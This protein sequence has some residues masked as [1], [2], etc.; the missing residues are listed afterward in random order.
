LTLKEKLRELD[1]VQPKITAMQPA[2][3]QASTLD[4]LLGGAEQDG[5]FWWSGVLPSARCMAPPVWAAYT[6]S[7]P[8]RWR[9]PDKM[10]AWPSSIW[11]GLCFG[12]RNDRTRWRNG[13][14]C[15]SCWGWPLRGEEFVVRQYFLRQP[16]EEA[17][18]LQ[19]LQALLEECMGLVTFNGKSFDIPLLRTRAV[20]HRLSVDFE[21]LHHFDV[22]H[23]ARRLWKDQV[24][25]CSLGGLESSILR[26]H[27]QQD[28]PG[29]LIPQIYF[30]FC[31]M[32]KLHAAGCSAHNRQ[33]I[34]STAALLVR[35]AQLVQNPLQDKRGAPISP[36]ELRRVAMLYRQLGDFDASARLF[37][38]LL[39]Q[40]RSAPRLEDHLVLG[41][42]YKSQRRHEEAKR[43]WHETV[44]RLPFHPLPYIEL[45][46]HFEHR[47][48]AIAQA[49]EWVERAMRNLLLSE[50]LGRSNGW[51]LYKN[52][53]LH[54]QARLQ[55][56]LQK[57]PMA[58]PAA[59]T[60]R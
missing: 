15:F 49:L 2:T 19:Q 56:K 33:D 23:A 59:W 25:S 11:P 34:V 17:A 26:Q 52:D 37:E 60:D 57:L 1:R 46:K 22:L 53:L 39:Q 12:Y 18:M 47:E 30:D 13:N 28:I 58:T 36:S 45:A 4:D 55:R 43:L 16:Y 54:R 42:C 51:L 10:N 40:P 27:R 32:A 14:P 35:I 29:A 38:Q 5:C 7:R 3:R 50:E 21:R 41:L 20:L 8:P 44:E 24:D 6:K 48:S 9:L 31:V